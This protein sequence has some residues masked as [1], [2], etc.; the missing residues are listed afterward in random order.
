MTLY[1]VY[2]A[3]GQFV[4]VYASTVGFAYVG[5]HITAEV[6]ARY[7]SSLLRQNM[8]YFDT[9]GAGEIVCPILIPH[10]PLC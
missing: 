10:L 5:E 9:L 2:L 7:L 8:A 4:T 6:R 3:V 1:Y